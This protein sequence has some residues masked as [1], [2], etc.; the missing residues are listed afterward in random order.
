MRELCRAWQPQAP[1][2][3]FPNTLAS[4]RFRTAG[5][6]PRPPRRAGP[7][8]SRGRA[9]LCPSMSPPDLSPEA[10]GAPTAP[11][12]TQEE[13]LAWFLAQMNTLARM[14]GAYNTT[15]TNVR[16]QGARLWLWG[17]LSGLFSCEVSMGAGARQLSQGDILPR[18]ARGQRRSITV[19]FLCR[20]RCTAW[21]PN[22]TQ[23][24]T[25]PPRRTLLASPRG[26]C[27]TP[28]SGRW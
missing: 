19:L 20:C 8:A 6:P 23:R 27:S 4:L 12:V 5:L 7:P 3:T 11:A 28:C 21:T 2:S 16:G 13:G 22:R 10:P 25:D 26:P 17:A 14:W 9:A 1:A 18:C 24:P 15:F